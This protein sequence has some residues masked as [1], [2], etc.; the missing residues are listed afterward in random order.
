MQ[1][2]DPT[3]EMEGS[4][5]MTLRWSTDVQTPNCGLGDVAIQKGS[6]FTLTSFC[7]GALP[8]NTLRVTFQ[9]ISVLLN[10]VWEM[11]WTPPAQ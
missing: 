7:K 9:D 6:T 8:N 11:D 1:S 2:S 10:D 3:I 5:S 4:L